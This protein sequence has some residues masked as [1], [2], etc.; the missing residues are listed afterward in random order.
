MIAVASM[1][2]PKRFA[3]A[4]MS[5]DVRWPPSSRASAGLFHTPMNSATTRSTR[6]GFVPPIATISAVGRRT[7]KP[8]PP[9]PGAPSPS[10]ASGVEI[11]STSTMRSAKTRS[12]E[13]YSARSSCPADFESR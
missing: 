7:W 13:R 8:S 6:T 4:S 1:S 12:D 9:I 11:S 5:G 3:A 10:T 2:S